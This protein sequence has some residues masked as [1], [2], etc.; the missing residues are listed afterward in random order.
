[1]VARNIQIWYNHEMHRPRLRKLA[2][3]GTVL[4]SLALYREWVQRNQPPLFQSLG[5][6]ENALPVVTPETAAQDPGNWND[7]V[8]PTVVDEE[9]FA[10]LVREMRA[11]ESRADVLVTGA[12]FGGVAAA[13][14]AADE[15]LTVALSTPYDLREEILAEAGEYAS[16]R[17]E[18]PYGSSIE[19]ELRAWTRVTRGTDENANGLPSDIA[20]FFL[21]RIEASQAIGVY[22]KNTVATF[23]RGPDGRIDRAILQAI[24]GSDVTAITFSYVIDGSNDG[25]ALAQ[26]GVP[27]RASWH[28]SDAEDVPAVPSEEA[29]EALATGYSMSGRTI[30][31]IGRRLEGAKMFMGVRDRGYNGM[32]VAPSDAD[33]CWQQEWGEN[34]KAFMADGTVLRTREVGCVATMRVESAFE[35]TV[36]L[37]FI[38]HG[39]DSLSAA[40]TFGSGQTVNLVKR[41]APSERFIRM[42]AFPLGP[43]S[44]IVVA[45]NSALPTD[46]VEGLV[47]RKMNTGYAAPSFETENGAQI[48]FT[49]G[50]WNSTVHDMYVSTDS[51]VGISDVVLDGVPFPVKTLGKGSYVLEGVPLGVGNHVL[52]IPGTD[53]VQRVSA[54]PVAPRRQGVHLTEIAHPATGFHSWSFTVAEGG[55][56]AVMAPPLACADEC[57][58]TITAKGSTVS[59]GVLRRG[60]DVISSAYPIDVIV[61]EAGSTFVVTTDGSYDADKEPIVSLIGEGNADLYAYG[62]GDIRVSPERTGNVYDLW[63][64]SRRSQRSVSSDDVQ[65]T[66][67][68]SDE[69]QFVTTALLTDDG[70]SAMGGG[71][72]ELLAIPN[73]MLDAYH[74]PLPPGGSAAS[75]VK[76]LPVGVYAV[77]SVGLENPGSV[78]MRRQSDGVVTIAMFDGANGEYRSSNA[79]VHDGL[80][81]SFSTDSEWPQTLIL[82]EKIHDPG[83][84]NASIQSGSL[85]TVLNADGLA[86]ADDVSYRDRS[87]GAEGAYLFSP[88]REGTGPVTLGTLHSPED[89]ERLRALLGDSYLL[90]RQGRTNL[91]AAQ[92]TCS[93]EDDPTC[94]PRRYVRDAAVFGTADA[95]TP[96]PVYPEGRRIIGRDL[97]TFS[98]AYAVRQPCVSCDREC[99]PG[100]FDGETCAVNGQNTGLMDAIATVHGS[101][102]PIAVSS[103]LEERLGTITSLMRTLRRDG[104]VGSAP[105]YFE[106]GFPRRDVSLTLGMLFS[107]DA[108]NVIAANATLSATHGA[109]VAL[110]SPST[111]L[112]IGSAAGHAVA[113]ALLHERSGIDFIASSPAATRRLQE[114]LVDRGGQILPVDTKD[115][116]P[117]LIRA[118]QRRVLDGS[119]RMVPAWVDDRLT[120]SAVPDEDRT[121]ISTA[122][123][124][125]A[126]RHTVREALK[127][128]PQSPEDGSDIELLDVGLRSGFLTSKVLIFSLNEIMKLPLDD[129]LLLKADYLL[130]AR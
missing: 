36:E 12:T 68:N 124:G 112:T 27:T 83:V 120:F 123:F 110:R 128:L 89:S 56:L 4:F 117:L 34:Q 35:D 16:R 59:E 37:F 28:D 58:V 126:N 98:G 70:A 55:R 82:H 122:I 51:I 62:T 96:L 1:M 79:Y 57:V 20:G 33:E 25:W 21:Q 24:D 66:M 41:F 85:L 90:L 127:I 45:T 9:A 91:T 48:A 38:N 75:I 10:E 77:A 129:A 65:R 94:D 103:P 80:P 118:L 84:V 44:P 111:K 105:T 49:T 93:M 47:A 63:L 64:R 106:E 67:P 121:A 72:A 54:V 101:S 40:V 81:S 97:L 29:M 32:F 74:L 119:A 76:D 26:A 19:R 7:P 102:G 92:E 53:G 78:A 17:V 114:Y 88:R 11:T 95:L 61:A 73:T 46:R 3:V 115:D 60:A 109:A 8:E 104:F 43:D 107:D 99:L 13:L 86:A 23:G 2:L 100:S 30:P 52:R 69:W 14:S 87:H 15:G 130:K 31:G 125:D 113:F 71:N 5:F 22:Q 50:G 39:N 18:T 116:D 42:G 108:P 6:F